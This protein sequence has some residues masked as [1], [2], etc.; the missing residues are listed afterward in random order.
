MN[1]SVGE[2]YSILRGRLTGDPEKAQAHL[3]SLDPNERVMRNRTESRSKKR[4]RK[5]GYRMGDTR[6]A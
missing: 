5:R 6:R 4:I 2:S 1:G 3:D